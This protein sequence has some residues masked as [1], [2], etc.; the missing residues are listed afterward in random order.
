VRFELPP[1][2]ATF[3][4]LEKAANIGRRSEMHN[5]LFSAVL[6]LVFVSQAHSTTIIF[7][8]DG[9]NILVA[10][11]TRASLT[12]GDARFG[13]DVTDRTCKIIPLPNVVF[14]ITGDIDYHKGSVG[15]LD[16]W[17]A[18]DDAKVA[19]KT[20]GDKSKMVADD[21]ALRSISHYQAFYKIAPQRVADLAKDHSHILELGQFFYWKDGIPQVL[22]KIIEFNPDQPSPVFSEERVV[23][24]TDREL[25]TNNNT[26]ELIDGK[27][28]IAQ[29][30]FVEWEKY[31]KKLTP[32]R[33]VWKHLQFLI[34]ETSKIDKTVSPESN[35]LRIPDRGASKWI[36][37]SGCGT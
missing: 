25:S 10:A 36:L 29:K 33:R 31:A 27:T 18:L 32:G 7:R 26:Q 24:I 23:T 19:S 17:S 1:H 5:R 12:T 15:D 6:L 34:E 21:W 4:P 16:N 13:Y 8:R 35:I 2:T 14:A 37:T 11:D 30:A 9:S 22:V 28:P 3:V 20:Y